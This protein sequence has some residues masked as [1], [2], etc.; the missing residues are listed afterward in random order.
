MIVLVKL[1]LAHLVGDFLLQPRSWVLHKEEKKAGSWKLYV[2]AC[3]H[4]ALVFLLFRDST[5]WP[6]ALAVGLSHLV[7]D[8]I[9]VY[10]QKEKTR[11]AWFLADQG[12]HLL[13][14]VALWWYWTAIPDVVPFLTSPRFILYVTA[15]FFLTQPMAIIVA[16]V[17][18]PWAERIPQENDHSLEN[19]GKYIGVLER[20]FVFGFIIANHW[21]AVG[22]LLAAKSVFRFGNLRQ[23]NERKLT[24]YVLIGTLLSFGA[25][26]LSAAIVGGSMSQ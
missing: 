20:L 3:I 4:A 18:R 8:T 10:F 5:T 13:V 21:E 22:F 16:T 14:I 26:I 7:T 24:E 2:H 9:R 23:S 1:V 11:T 6:L 17:M 12:I 15:L 19:A 25:A